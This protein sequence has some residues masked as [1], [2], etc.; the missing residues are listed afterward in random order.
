MHIDLTRYELKAKY[1]MLSPF[2]TKKI[3]C[4]VTIATEN[5]YLNICVK[6]IQILRKFRIFLIYKFYIVWYRNCNTN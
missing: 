5:M 1:F 2:S 4:L 3:S 6:N